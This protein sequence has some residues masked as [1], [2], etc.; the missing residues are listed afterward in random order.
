MVRP[1]A[2]MRGCFHHGSVRYVRAEICA[3]VLAGASGACVMLQRPRCFERKR[4]ATRRKTGTGQP[5]CGRCPRTY[6][7]RR[8]KEVTEVPL[9]GVTLATVFLSRGQ[10][11]AEEVE[12]QQ[13]E[14]LRD[15]LLGGHVGDAR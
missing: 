14:V 3:R 6:S 15:R 9:S 10:R 12:L 7:S 2:T 8:L 1:A 5:R 4:S 11:T 13:Q